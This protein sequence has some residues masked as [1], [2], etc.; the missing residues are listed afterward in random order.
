M[1]RKPHVLLLGMQFPPARGSGVYR[2]RSWANHLVRNGFDVTVLA[3]DRQYWDDVTGELDPE[4]ASTVDPAVHVVEVDVPHEH[5]IQDLRRMSWAHANFP[6]IYLKTHTRLREKIFPEVYAPLLPTFVRKGLGVHA[7]KRVDLVLA[8]GNPYAQY[9]AAYELGRLLRRP[10]VVDYH[11]PWTL[12]LWKEED[13]FPPGHAAFRWEKK[14]IDRAALVITVNDPL[15]EWYRQRYPQAAERVRLVENGLAPEVVGVPT[16][17]PVPADRPLSVGF[18]GTIRN[19]LPLAE[20]LD[21]WQLARK[22]PELAD[23]QMNFYGYLG[24]FRQQTEVIRARIEAGVDGVQYCGPVPQTRIAEMFSR[25]D[26]MAMLL[27][28]SRFVTAGKGYDY[29]AAGRPV[30]GVHDPRNHTTEV[31]ADYP[32][33]YGAAS[34]TPEAIRDALVAAARAARSQ[35]QE[36]FE[37]CRAE[38]MRHTWDATMAPVAQEMKGIIGG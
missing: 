11:D 37:A 29:M 33:F 5:L 16:W 24:F 4:L 23:A 20:Y 28:S 27:T 26:V 38:A 1:T 13:A 19:D 10:Y 6:R 30:V 25:T 2:I 36:Q 31:F 8:T 18:L 3:A 14:I 22:E 9:G 12:D 35:T 15:V 21:G 17:A 34:V 32:L 7:R